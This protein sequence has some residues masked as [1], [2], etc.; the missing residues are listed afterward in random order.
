[1]MYDSINIMNWT[2]FTP[3]SQLN[4]QHIAINNDFGIKYEQNTLEK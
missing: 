3:R 4:M 2:R 1:M